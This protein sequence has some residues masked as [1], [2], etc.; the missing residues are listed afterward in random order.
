M[1][2]FLTTSYSG[3]NFIL[4]FEIENIGVGTAVSIRGEYSINN[5]SKQNVVVPMLRPNE[6]YGRIRPNGLPNIEDRSYYEA[7]PTTINIE[8]KFKDIFNHNF[9]YEESLDVSDF[10]AHFQRSI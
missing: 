4:D 2:A 5:E 10:A 6:K 8:L 7:N 9:T 3:P 1:K